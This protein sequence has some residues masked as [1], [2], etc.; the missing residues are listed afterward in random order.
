M[1]PEKKAVV[2]IYVLCSFL[3]FIRITSKQYMVN[4]NSSHEEHV[5]LFSDLNSYLWVF[6]RI[7]S[8]GFSRTFSGSFFCDVEV[9]TF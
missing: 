9:M 8:V 6:N 2:Q 1:H 3:Y 7:L 4:T 5:C